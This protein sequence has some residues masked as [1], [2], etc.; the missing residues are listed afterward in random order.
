MRATPDFDFALSESALMIREA[1][2]RFAD[3]QIADRRRHREAVALAGP[4][5]TEPAGFV[6][7]ARIDIG[8]DGLK[9]EQE[10]LRRIDAISEA[11]AHAVESQR[12]DV[13]D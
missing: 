11:A 13:H 8:A 6:I 12:R 4:F 3:E 7:V 1:T 10:R 2:A 5:P 9:R